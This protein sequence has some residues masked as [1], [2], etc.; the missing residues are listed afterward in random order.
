MNQQHECME[1]ILSSVRVRR[2][3][4][5]DNPVVPIQLQSSD[6]FTFHC[7]Q[8]ISCW[9]LCCHGVDLTLT[10]YCILR[11]SRRL[12]IRPR[13][14]LAQYTVP[15]L[16][17][18]AGLPVAKLKMGGESGEGPC[19]FVSTEG[20]NV[21]DDRPVTC[22]YYPLGLATVKMKGAEKQEDF[23]FSVREGFCCGH[24]QQY[25]QKVS[26][27]RTIQGIEEYDKINRG[28]MDVMMKAASWKT[29]GGPYG[30]EMTAQTQRMFFMVSTDVDSLRQFVFH[31]RF[32][33]TYEVSE[34]AVKT[35]MDD[36]EALLQLGFDWLKNVLFNER[37]I[38]MKEHILQAAVAKARETVGAS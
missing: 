5:S 37:T 1:N 8:G 15:A 14:F 12:N 13:E 7:Y 27:F 6:T 23:Y 33:E 2:Q 31:T 29:L 9:N 32:L 35:I 28:W 21:Y 18:R 26:V 38:I 10:P 24:D 4:A 36:D 22:R 20:C 17:E 19:P 25:T 16:W 34:E 30:K 11:L 3:T